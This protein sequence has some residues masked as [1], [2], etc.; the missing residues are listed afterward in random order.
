MKEYP[1]P[2]PPN[3]WPGRPYTEEQAPKVGLGIKDAFR[4][5][6]EWGR[7][8]FDPWEEDA[9]RMD[10]MSIHKRWAYLQERGL[11]V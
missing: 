4:C 9:T 5:M 11:L 10:E 8:T 1:S 3:G 2:I 7:E 6:D